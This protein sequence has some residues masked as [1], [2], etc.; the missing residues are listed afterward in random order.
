MIFTHNNEKG[1]E[2]LHL[3]G[4]IENETSYCIAK[5]SETSLAQITPS[6]IL[7]YDFVTKRVIDSKPLNDII[8]ASINGNSVSYLNYFFLKMFI[9]F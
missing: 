8:I 3:D 9:Y 7:L 6:V 5:I 2:Q 1:F 4:F